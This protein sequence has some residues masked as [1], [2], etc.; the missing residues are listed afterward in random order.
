MFELQGCEIW[1]NS[2]L[3][4]SATPGRASLESNLAIPGALTFD[5]R[6]DI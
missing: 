2:L 3:N 5:G 4:G 1:V 6:I